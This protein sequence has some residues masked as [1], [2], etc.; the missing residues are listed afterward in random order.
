M[1]ALSRA[2]LSDRS[3]SICAS[4]RI[5]HS[6]RSTPLLDLIR[7]ENWI[8][9]T[10]SERED[11][12]TVIQAICALRGHALRPLSLTRL[13]KH[14]QASPHHLSHVFTQVVGMNIKR[15]HQLVRLANA[16]AI[17]AETTLS[18]TKVA[19]ECGYDSLGS[20]TT[21]F[22][23]AVGLTPSDFRKCLH[24]VDTD[25]FTM[26]SYVPAAVID[27]SLVRIAIGV[28]VE[29]QFSGHVFLAICRLSDGSIMNCAAF[30]YAPHGVL[31]IQVC[32][33]EAIAILAAAYPSGSEFRQAVV[34][35]PPFRGRSKPIE[36]CGATAK[37]LVLNLR[38][39]ALVDPP[40]VAALP[41][42]LASAGPATR[43]RTTLSIGSG[44]SQTGTIAI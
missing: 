2:R 12:Q 41:L 8:A 37:P 27:D 42:I 13:A 24:L 35:E 20:F 18:I 23:S 43:S 26:P 34:A 14:V 7:T 21:M 9:S 38:T 40:L 33:N 4:A 28:R 15:F 39:P 44:I 3:Y 17:L 32:R 30:P 31:A 5:T 29:N 10:V 11:H 19:L 16:K 6:S 25:A 36:A 1:S 22:K